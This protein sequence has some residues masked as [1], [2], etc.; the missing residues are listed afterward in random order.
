MQHK[1][2]DEWLDDFKDYRIV[3]GF[4]IS[5][6]PNLKV[7]VNWCHRHYPD[8]PYLQQFMIDEWSA[9]KATEKEI[10]HATRVHSLNS[11]IRHI[12]DR[13]GTFRL[14]EHEKPEPSPE[15]RSI[16]DEELANVLRAADE[17]KIT[18]KGTNLY[19][20]SLLKALEMPVMIRL[21][22]STGMRI[23][24]ARLL[25]RENV[26]LENGI[27]YIKK[28]K[29]YKERLVALD[30]GMNDL[31]KKYDQKMQEIIPDRIVFFPHPN[32]GYRNRNNILC[33]W[34]ELCDKYNKSTKR[35]KGEHGL[36]IYSLRHRYVTENIEKMPKNGYV[37]DKNMLALSQ[38][39]GH[40][41]IDLTIKHYFHLT[42][43][44]ADLIQ[45]KMEET[46]E[47]IIG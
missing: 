6:I 15:P 42:D 22:Y 3:Y 2:I 10:T 46:F 29:G 30:W 24:E 33:I 35:E 18:K 38:S 40:T 20:T 39:L 36:V 37:K 4:S 43:Q 5:I 9:R 32:G 16:T 26:D 7:F 8:E 23:P 34:R 25:D 31:L 14:A 13:G 12:N 17:L 11:L 47:S 21:L 1:T 27:I 44:A 19:M 28:G 45:E 41:S